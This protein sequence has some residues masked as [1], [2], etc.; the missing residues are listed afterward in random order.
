MSE[1]V[2]ELHASCENCSSNIQS[3]ILCVYS[4]CVCGVFYF[5]LFLLTIL[6]FSICLICNHFQMG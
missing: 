4:V 6:N 5:L 1:K 3:I 2:H